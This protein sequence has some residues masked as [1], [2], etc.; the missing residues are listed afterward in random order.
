VSKNAVWIAIDVSPELL[1]AL[2]NH[3]GKPRGSKTALQRFVSNLI[4][5]WI[6]S[7]M[8]ELKT[9]KERKGEET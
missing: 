9:A 2:A 6:M 5:G 8:D 4:D 3:T 7:M 1:E